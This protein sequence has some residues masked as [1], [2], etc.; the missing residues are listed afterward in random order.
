MRGLMW[1]M[2][3]VAMV[4]GLSQFSS[5]TEQVTQDMKSMTAAQLEEAADTCRAQKDYGQAIQYFNEALRRDKKNAVLYNKR[6]MAE[7]KSNDLQSARADF[8]K[9]AK[10]NRKFAD[11]LNNAGAVYFLQKNFSQAARYFKKAVALDETRATFHVN[12]GAAWFSQK[13]LDQAINEY[14]RALTLDPEALIQNAR[15]GIS[16]QISSPEERA[17]YDYMLAKIQAKRGN[18]QEC[19]VCL[20]KAKEDGYR[21]IANVYKDEEFRRLWND[22]R[23]AE[24]AP[25]PVAK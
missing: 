15:A 2:M 4:V 24:I 16:A 14:A 8:E 19:L 20:K 13:K 25:P 6:G 18:L 10:V 22:P 23:L 1:R 7:L 5:G 17:T 11:A 9:A 12:L 3:V 21:N